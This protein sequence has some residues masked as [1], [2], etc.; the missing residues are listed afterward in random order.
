MSP[1][2]VI[3]PEGW[4]SPVLRSGRSVVQCSPMEGPVWATESFSEMA[5]GW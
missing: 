2:F 3:D 5:E 1:N 4:T